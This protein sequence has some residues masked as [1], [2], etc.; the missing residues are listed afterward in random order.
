[1]RRLGFAMCIVLAGCETPA[2]PCADCIT[3]RPDILI[4]SVTVAG[5]ARDAQ[6]GLV[7]VRGDSIDITVSIRNAGTELIRTPVL[8]LELD[9]E[10]VVV[11]RLPDVRAG[12]THRFNRRVATLL[13]AI[14]MDRDTLRV[15][16]TV[17]FADDE[18]DNNTKLS[19]AFHVALP[20]L[21]LRASLGVAYNVGVAYDVAVSVENISRHATLP[22]SRVV[23]C[24][25]NL[26]AS[27][28]RAQ[29]A[30]GINPLGVAPMAPGEIRHWTDR[31]TV[32]TGITHQNVIDAVA[33]TPCIGSAQLQTN[34]L[35]DSRDRGCSAP[36]QVFVRPDYEA[37]QPP[38]LIPGAPVTAGASCDRPCAIY[39][40]A[41]DVQPG[42][43]YIIEDE[44][45]AED[46]TLRWRTRYRDEPLD[47]SSERGLQPSQAGIIYAV[48]AP[49]FCGA[50]G[51]HTVV[52][53]RPATG[54]G[55]S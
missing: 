55:R 44:K 16:A 50:S 24:V 37:C 45:G 11:V 47:I 7:V 48:T 17:V 13:P 41:I 53:R 42:Q 2:E 22:A 6:T 40:Y 46:L 27:C 36:S 21:R 32:P 39:A 43:T 19:D 31:I 51:E 52:L 12:G 1:M 38:R 54:P 10:P 8:A 28:S 35:L 25:H 4:E 3:V 14:L 20:A 30:A 49:K 18:P 29:G 26:G 9:A 15:R 5:S 23:F 33:F 34:D